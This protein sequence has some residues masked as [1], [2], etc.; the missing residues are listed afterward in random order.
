MDFKETAGHAQMS[1]NA[2]WESTNAVSTP[3]VRTTLAPIIAH[4]AMA[5]VETGGHAKML[6][7]ARREPIIAVSML[8]V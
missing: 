8:T 2:R 7:N 1:T 6:T 4:A 5:F 3:I